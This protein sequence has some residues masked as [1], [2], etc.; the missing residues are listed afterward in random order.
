MLSARALSQE[1][2]GP[3]GRPQD[4][5]DFDDIEVVHS[6]EAP[7][8]TETEVLEVESNAE[9]HPGEGM[10]LKNLRSTMKTKDIKLW[11]YMYRIPPS[12]EI[13][14]PTTHERVD[15]VMHGWVAVYEL[16]LKD[17]MRFPIPKLISD[18]CDHY[19]IAPSQVMP[20]AWR[21]LTSSESL[22]V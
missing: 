4:D 2:A 3:S 8:N 13:R 18:V 21:V 6:T 7:Y 9:S 19:E 12:V 17:G 22:S 20:N 5:V 14:V 10:L 16:M 15:W 1:G 11:R